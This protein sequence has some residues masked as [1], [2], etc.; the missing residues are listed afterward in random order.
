MKAGLADQLT[1]HVRCKTVAIETLNQQAGDKCADSVHIDRHTHTQAKKNMG[2]LVNR[3]LGA[4]DATCGGSILPLMG[5]KLTLKA[6]VMTQLGRRL[7]FSLGCQIVSACL[8]CGTDALSFSGCWLV[9]PTAVCV[10]ELSMLAV[11]NLSEIVAV[12]SRK[13]IYD[14]I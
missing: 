2:C 9:F 3:T 12:Y 11:G 13:L 8:S 10:Q 14:C 7:T 6:C 4:V 1:W 5:Q